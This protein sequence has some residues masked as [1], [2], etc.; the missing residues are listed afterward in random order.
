MS[1][2]TRGHHRHV[3]RGKGKEGGEEV[4]AQPDAVAE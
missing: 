1:E 3:E 4:D 2:M